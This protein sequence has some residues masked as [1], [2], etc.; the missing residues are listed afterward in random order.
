[1]LIFVEYS[2]KERYNQQSIKF[3]CFNKIT[4]NT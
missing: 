1:M 2:R 3:L 4:K